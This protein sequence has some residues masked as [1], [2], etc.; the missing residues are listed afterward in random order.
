ML[1]GQSGKYMGKSI[2]FYANWANFMKGLCDDCQKNIREC[3]H[4]RD[5]NNKTTII[6]MINILCDVM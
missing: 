5:D 6:N 4:D 1:D 3:Y 2:D